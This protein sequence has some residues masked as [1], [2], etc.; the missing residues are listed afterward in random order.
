MCESDESNLNSHPVIKTSFGSALLHIFFFIDFLAIA[1]YY[2]MFTF[3]GEKKIASKLRLEI[4]YHQITLA[5]DDKNA[6]R[7]KQK[8]TI[9]INKPRLT[10][11]EI[12]LCN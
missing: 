12:Q 10:D 7:M 5:K 2:L 8:K 9:T 3:W 6:K 1:L 4:I 11:C